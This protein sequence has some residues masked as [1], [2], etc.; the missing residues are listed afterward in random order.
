MK[1]TIILLMSVLIFSAFASCS[2]AE[3]MGEVFLQQYYKYDVSAAERW[4]GDNA[5]TAKI[6][7]EKFEKYLTSEEF[8]V[9]LV[10]DWWE[11]FQT[12]AGPK[13]INCN[14]NDIVLEKQEDAA[15]ATSSL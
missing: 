3:P 15:S 6:M 2:P 8:H 4:A 10:D 14:A 11:A 12:L 13:K 9:L 5:A 7:S 1:K